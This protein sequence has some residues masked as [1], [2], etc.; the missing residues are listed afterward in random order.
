MPDR[1][2][3]PEEK[4]LLHEVRQSEIA[5][6]RS[7]EERRL[8]AIEWTQAVDNRRRA[9]LAMTSHA[10]SPLSIQRDYEREIEAQLQKEFPGYEPRGLASLET[11]TGEDA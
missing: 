5:A 9:L 11:G 8:D 6:R 4:A 2:M 7:Q 10:S 1:A 3:A